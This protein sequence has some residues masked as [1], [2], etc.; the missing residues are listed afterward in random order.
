MICCTVFAS[1]TATLVPLASAP[2]C[3]EPKGK[4]SARAFEA[5][6]TV[7]K[8]VYDSSDDMSRH[9]LLF[10]LSTFRTSLNGNPSSVPP[11]HQ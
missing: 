11:C 8:N 6:N 7:K 9:G 5:A 1:A 4:S 2:K 10:S 3:G